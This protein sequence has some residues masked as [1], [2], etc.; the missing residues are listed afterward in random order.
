MTVF[1]D[2]LLRIKELR[3]SGEIGVADC[4]HGTWEQAFLLRD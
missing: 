4:L 3:A 1:T 2:L